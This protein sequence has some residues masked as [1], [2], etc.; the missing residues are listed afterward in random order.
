[1]KSPIRR[2]VT[3]H[4]DQGKAVVLMDGP[5][6]NVTI[7]KTGFVSTVL[8]AV[9]ESPADI[10]GS[11][12]RAARDVALSPPPNG[13][14]LRVVDFPPVTPD[15]MKAADMAGEMGPGVQV[16]DAAARTHAFMHRTRTIDYAVVLSG[17]IEMRLDDSS[18]HLKAGDFVIQQGTNHAWVNNSQ[19]DCRVAFIMI[20]A[21]EPPAWS[22]GR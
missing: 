13:A 20:D 11:G 19:Q 18:V 7:R 21:L 12:D 15:S 17:E 5:A 10:S 1:M 3:G 6:S 14:V 8:W 9:D 2:V 4:D 22:E 16:S